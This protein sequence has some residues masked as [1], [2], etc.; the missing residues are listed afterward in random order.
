MNQKN[1]FSLT[2][3]MVVTGLLV[4]IFA[5]GHMALLSSQSAWSTTDSQI[6][7]QESI[8][9]TLMRISTE[10]KQT[11]TDSVGAA[12]YSVLNGAGPNGSDVIRFSVPL[13]LCAGDVMDASGD[14]STWGAPLSWGN[15]GCSEKVRLNQN[16]LV[17]M[18]HITGG[19]PNIQTS[20]EITSVNVQTH[21]DHG[22]W[23]GDCTTCNT[24]N[25]KFIEYRINSDGELLRRVL[26]DSAS[27]VIAEDIFAKNLT[28]F[29]A[30]LNGDQTII[31]LN[32][33]LSDT[34]LQGR[35]LTDSRSL[36]VFLKNKR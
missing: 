3:L 6:G 13:C 30:T 25:K 28:D 14:V 2:E 32:L 11:G 35:Q 27:T 33:S 34:A 8:R 16:N 7:M 21:L 23:M 24:I 4:I 17:D 9:Q 26:N 20:S 29:Q 10:L 18:C 22:D 5:A 36:K 15:N 1:G 12:Q 19:D 31:T